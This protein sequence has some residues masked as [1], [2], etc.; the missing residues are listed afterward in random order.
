ML[1]RTRNVEVVAMG[2]HMHTY[3]YT[4][5][6]SVHLN[7][8][9]HI[10]T[11]ISITSSCYPPSNALPSMCFSLSPQPSTQALLPPI[12]CIP[13]TL[14]CQHMLPYYA[15]ISV[16]STHTTFTL[17]YLTLIPHFQVKLFHDWQFY[18]HKVNIYTPL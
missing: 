3:S 10:C 1:Y 5:L 11:M 9:H 18:M 2:S 17:R 8:L 13:P 7:I 14:Q 12:P 4:G 15:T 6:C 16:H